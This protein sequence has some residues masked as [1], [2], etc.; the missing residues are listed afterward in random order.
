MAN[1]GANFDSEVFRK[2][3]PMIIATNRASAIMLPVRL[4]YQSAGYPAGTV[5]ARNTTDG[6]YQAYNDAGSSGINTANSVLF[7]EH[8]VEDFDGT[9]ATSTTMAVAIFGG[10]TLYEDKLTG[11]DAAA[12]VDLKSTSIVDATGVTT[13][14][15]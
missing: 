11:L 1:V 14:K 9:A 4:R 6:F 12:K 7:E 2:N 15:F 3:F 8:P 10:C 5:L 13:L